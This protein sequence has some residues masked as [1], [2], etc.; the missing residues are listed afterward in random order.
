MTAETSVKY[1]HSGMTGAPVLNGSAGSLV[2]VLDS[3]L[4]TGFGIKTL[5][6]VTVSNEVATAVLSTGASFEA[7][8]VIEVVGATPAG[9]NGLR[10]ISAVDGTTITFSVPGVPDGVAS[11]TVTAK[12]AGAGWEKVF[13]G[14]NLGVYR[15]Q[16]ASGIRHCL[17]VNDTGTAISRVRAYESM[18]G[19]NTGLRP[20][21]VD[22]QVSGGGYWPKSD[23]ANTTARTWTLIADDRGFYLHVHALA[24]GAGVAGSVWTFGDFKSLRSADAYKSV[25]FCAAAA[26]NAL[27]GV[28][29][30]T[31]EYVSYTAA[32]TGAFV[33]RSYTGVGSAQELGHG[34][35]G[36][37]TT[38][39]AAA[40]A[41][42]ST[43]VP[44]YP[45]GANNGLVLVRKTLVER[46]VALRGFLRGVHVPAQ[47]CHS[48]FNPLD[49]LDGQGDLLGRKLLAVKCGGTAG[50]GSLGVLFFD[51][52]G[53]WS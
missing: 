10:R 21:P 25:L 5:D 36:L 40:G 45:N 20:Y 9:I 39:G 34:A 43:V 16:N 53:P 19:M 23:T 6:S 30:A 27:T 33:S 31:V 11:G 38:G 48:S 24:S 3:C 37:V 49:K 32:G 14:T 46:N 52:T 28:S 13:A 2:A 4:V 44:T 8:V 17:W 15:G 47:L 42:S 1:F 26:P 7:D 35:E 51:I 18:T 41:S 12:V 29:S 22:T 50:T